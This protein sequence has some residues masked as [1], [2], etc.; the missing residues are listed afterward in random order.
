[1]TNTAFLSPHTDMKSLEQLY[2]FR[3][4]K[5]V[6]EFMDENYFL[7]S[8][9]LEA[10]TKI[11][12]YFPD[13]ELCLQVHYDPEIMGEVN[14]LLWINHNFEAN[15]AIDKLHHLDCNWGLNIPHEVQDKF[16]VILGAL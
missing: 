8:T 3:D 4:K 5:E 16:C 11:R 10:P 7:L 14:L 6:L 12:P 9:L 15:E 13:A 2:S 1:M